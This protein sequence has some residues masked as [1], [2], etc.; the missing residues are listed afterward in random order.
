M[1]EIN[2]QLIIKEINNEIK[3]HTFILYGSRVNNTFNIDS[4]IDILC[5]KDKGESYQYSKVINGYF[6]DAWVNNIYDLSNTPDFLKI[7]GGK[8]LIEKNNI[9]TKILEDV[10]SMY[11]NTSTGFSDLEINNLKLWSDKMLNRAKKLDPE[12]N[13]RKIW[14]ANDLL[15]LYFNVRNIWYLGS[16]KS[17]IWFKNNDLE[18]YHLFD[19]LYKNPT[20]ENLELVKNKVFENL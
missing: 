10:K 19:N 20:L 5:I 18:S 7:L 14:L 6:V 15:E 17:F 2:Y 3:C 4:D 13:F 12:G 16:K 11:Q 8:V 1:Q 9:G